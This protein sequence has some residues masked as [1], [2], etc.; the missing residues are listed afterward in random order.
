[1]PF[2]ATW[3]CHTKWSKPDRERQISHDIACMWNL[4]KRK[5]EVI[6]KDLYTKQKQTHRHRKQ[7]YGYQR[8]QDMGGTNQE[9]GINIYTLFYIYTIYV[10]K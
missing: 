9:F 3:V 4:K 1:M 7:A 10:Y 6:Q 5:K 2:A 8:G